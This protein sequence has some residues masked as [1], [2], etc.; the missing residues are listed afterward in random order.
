MNY[1]KNNA[2]IQA[3]TL[4]LTDIGL[5]INNAIEQLI[6]S[7]KQTEIE[8]PEKI[9]AISNAATPNQ[10]IFYDTPEVIGKQNIPMPFCLIIPSNLHF[11]E[12]DALE[13]LKE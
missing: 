3:H 11:M 12:S 1:I 9:I 2:S 10:K 7:S 8:L 5:E 4:I 6:E 13:E